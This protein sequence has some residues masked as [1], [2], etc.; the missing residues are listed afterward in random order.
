MYVI[1]GSKDNHIFLAAYAFLPS[2]INR[3]AKE[4]S[5]DEKKAILAF[6]VMYREEIRE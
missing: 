6:W 5:T 4:W 3:F 1:F 2:L